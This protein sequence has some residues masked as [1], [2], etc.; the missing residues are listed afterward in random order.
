MRTTDRGLV[1]VGNAPVKHVQ[2]ITDS[3]HALLTRDI[4]LLP[5]LDAARRRETSEEHAMGGT[6][7][8]GPRECTVISY[9]CF[10]LL[11]THENLFNLLS[12]FEAMCSV[13][14]RSI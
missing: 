8:G 6:R 1:R 14:E 4:H 7:S 3:I 12:L 5:Q 10:A 9:H 2:K 11:G 13:W